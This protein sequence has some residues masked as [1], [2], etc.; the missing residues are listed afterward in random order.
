MLDLFKF[1]ELC[2]NERDLSEKFKLIFHQSRMKPKFSKLFKTIAAIA[3][4]AIGAIA[5]AT[6]Y[7]VTDSWP[8]ES[9]QIVLPQLKDRVE[10]VRDSWGIPHIYA[11]N[12]HDLFMAQGYIHAQD[13]FW[14]MDFWRHI[15]SGRLAEMFGQ[16]QVSSDRFLRT[17]GWVEIVEREFAQIPA[18]DRAILDAYAEGVNAYLATHQ[19]SSLSLEYAIL[20]R[21]NPNYKPESWQ[22]V[23]TLTWLKVMA[24][25]MA[26]NMNKE[27]ERA[28]LLKTLTPEQVDEL[29]PPYPSDRPIVLSNLKIGQAGEIGRVSSSPNSQELPPGAIEELQA[30]GDRIATVD[31]LL[32]TVGSGIGSNSWVVSGSKTVTGKPLLADD[33]HLGVQMPSIWYQ[34]GLHCTP[35]GPDCPYE[36]TGFSFAGVSG[37]IIGHTDRMA[38]GFTNTVA[39]VTDLYVEKINPLNPNQYEVNGEW[40]DME[41]IAQTIQVAGSESIS[42]T[43]RRTRH[44]PIISDT[45]PLLDNFDRLAG[46]NIPPKYAIAMR[47]TALEPS[48]IFSVIRKLNSARNWQDFRAAAKDFDIASQN[49][50]YA[51]VEGNIGYQMPGKI[52]IRAGDRDGRYPVFGWTN[53]AEWEGYIPFEKLPFSFN[54]PEGY[55][56]TA[57][58]P[59]VGDDYPYLLTK[60]WEYGFRAERIKNAIASQNRPF[61]IADF[62]QLQGDNKNLMAEKLV[63]ILLQLP[64]ED[65]RLEGARILLQD[66]DFQEHMDKAAPAIFEM[67]WKHLLADTFE[68]DLPE[69][70]WPTGATRWIEVTREQVDK[71][72]S[73][74]WD[75]K[76]TPATETRDRIMS[77]AFAEAIDELEKE[78]GKNP[79]NWHWGDL[80]TVTFRN[81]SLG[82]SG[83]A[84][85]ERLFNRGPFATSGGNGIVNVSVWNVSQSFDVLHIPSMRAI[86]DLSDLNSSIA[87]HSTGQSGHA[88]HRHYDDAIEPWRK[89]E[90]HPMLCDR[91]SITANAAATLTLVP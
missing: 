58:N 39:D 49:L 1:G 25:D 64:L 87:I 81:Q 33:P 42:H 90:Y 63:P 83:I 26:Q 22:P 37:V 89:I 78:L 17:L 14:Q 8:Q 30:I 21:I 4:I 72:N 47:W 38:W 23:H 31:T 55:I 19:G 52:P 48:T 91:D 57:N 20:Q 40:V 65:R 59:I 79:R 61:S 53:D 60:D 80:H 45:Y 85:I 16:S 46:I 76:T 73:F 70:Y 67:F 68:D 50:I 71:P 86:A 3:L 29:F 7:L 24:W 82:K 32:D 11:S 43:V 41:T 66:W 34:I 36:V 44:G 9:G 75:D 15:G 27:I 54:P 88:F 69:K 10:V 35:V 84:P 28:I 74:W 77:Q 56:V 12:S 62:Q 6:V 13:R 5:S 18:E 2:H 51:D